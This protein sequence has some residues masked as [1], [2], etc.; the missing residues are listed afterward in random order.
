VEGVMN[1]KLQDDVAKPPL[2][3]EAAKLWLKMIAQALV[4]T[5]TVDSPWLGS[6]RYYNC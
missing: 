5:I 6:Q 2:S 4:H 1:E 3:V